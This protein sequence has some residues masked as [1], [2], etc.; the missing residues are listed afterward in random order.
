MIWA[1]LSPQ[2]ASLGLER[3]NGGEGGGMFSPPMTTIIL[4][5]T[6]YRTKCHCI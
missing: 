6:E 3:G 2:I 5:I 4:A 1:T